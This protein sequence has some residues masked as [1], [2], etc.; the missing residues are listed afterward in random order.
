MS[1]LSMRIGYPG[2]YLEQMLAGSE[3]M[4]PDVF[5]RVIDVVIDGDLDNLKSR[6]PAAPD[7]K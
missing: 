3:P 7:A 1:A 2:L 6:T 4:S 5:M